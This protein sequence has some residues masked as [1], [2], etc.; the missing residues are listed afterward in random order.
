MMSERREAWVARACG[1][2]ALASRARK[3]S[4]TLE[5][6]CGLLLLLLLLEEEGEVEVARAAEGPMLLS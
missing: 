6:R 2:W 5:G 4:P 1:P 3:R